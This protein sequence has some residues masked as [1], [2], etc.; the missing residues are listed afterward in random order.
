MTA[1]FEGKW[2]WY[3][4]YGA[5]LGHKEA[6]A[7]DEMLSREKEILDNIRIRR[8]GLAAMWDEQQVKN[9]ALDAVLK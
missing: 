6:S 1:I 7:L 3:E 8:R 9:K 2:M 4:G 5:T